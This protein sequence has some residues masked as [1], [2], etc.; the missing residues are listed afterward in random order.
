[1][2]PKAASF[3]LDG[4]L[5]RESMLRRVPKRL[6]ANG[7]LR[8][9]SVPALLDHYTE[10]LAKLFAVHGRKFAP[11]EIEAMRSLLEDKLDEGFAAARNSYVHVD[12]QTDEP[13]KTSLSYKFYVESWTIEE[14]HAHWIKTRA[15]ELFGRRPDGKVMEL[16]RSLGTPASVPVLG[17]G[18]ATGTG[19]N[20]LALAR[21]GFP[22]HAVEQNP[23]LAQLLRETAEKE[24][25]AVTLFEGDV[26]NAELGVPK[27]HYALVTLCEVVSDFRDEEAVKG[28]F[29]RAAELVRPNGLLLFNAF[30]PVGGYQPDLLARQLSFVL[31]S[32][33][34]TRD[35]LRAAGAAHGFSLVSEESVY[36]FEK[37]RYP[38]GAWPPTAWFEEW[39]RGIDT[40]DLPM[41]RAP[42]E[43][44]W[45]VWKKSG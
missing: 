34:F 42:V 15:P 12:F 28:L 40:F 25:L 14:E 9:P 22:T 30:L 2:P 37:E 1:M 18:A 3:E 38:E 27:A 31:W 45:L 33:I 21:A 43:M 35:E 4:Q 11:E 8:L 26:L 16:A 39:T 5:L 10:M 23:S 19:R 32:T 36:E 41:S 7:H 29:A 24:G 17:V 6:H 44:R 20:T 13:P